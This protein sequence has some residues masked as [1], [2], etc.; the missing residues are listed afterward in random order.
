[1]RENV[2]DVCGENENIIKPFNPLKIQFVQRSKHTP[3]RSLK[4]LK[5]VHG[6]NRCFLMTSIQRRINILCEEEIGFFF[7]VN[8]VVGNETVGH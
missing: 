8:L 6:N 3:S 2:T 1:M 7:Y 4:P 5:F